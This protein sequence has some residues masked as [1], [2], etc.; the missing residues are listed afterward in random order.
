[1]GTAPADLEAADNSGNL[2]PTATE[3]R[4]H[5]HAREGIFEALAGVFEE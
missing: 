3:S 5:Q 1:M 2:K 4:V